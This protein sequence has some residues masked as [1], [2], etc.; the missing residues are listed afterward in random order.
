MKGG[1]TNRVDVEVTG[2]QNDGPVHVVVVEVLEGNI[3]N[4]SVA[5]VWTCPSLEPSSVL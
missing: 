4:E 2:I 5:D 3:L 1:D